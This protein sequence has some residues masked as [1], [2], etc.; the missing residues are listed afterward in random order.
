M[1]DYIHVMDLAQGHLS[2]LSRLYS[3]AGSFTVNLG[4][5]QGVTV[6]QAV[7]AFEKACGTPIPITVAPRR[8]GDIATCYASANKAKELLD[9]KAEKTLLQMVNDHWRWQKQN[10]NGY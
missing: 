8:A 5:G 1:R 2:A 3:R 9:W 4:T 10:P 7:A 6:L